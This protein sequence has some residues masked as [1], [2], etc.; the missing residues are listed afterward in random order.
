MMKTALIKIVPSNIL[1]LKQLNK[2][3]GKMEIVYA[4]Q[5]GDAFY[6][7]QEVFEKAKEEWGDS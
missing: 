5:D 4:I 1:P 3:T 7:S 2:K 6:V